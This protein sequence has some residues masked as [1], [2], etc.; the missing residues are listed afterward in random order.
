MNSNDVSLIPMHPFVRQFV[1]SIIKNIRGE[2]FDYRERPVIHADMVP[3]GSKGVRMASMM[4][5]PVLESAKV[6]KPPIKIAPRRRDMSALVAPIGRTRNRGGQRMMASRQVATLTR[7]EP[8]I[9]SAEGTMATPVP[10]G[11][12]IISE[13]YGKI[14]PLLDDP[15][16]STIECEGVNKPIM[17]L[18]A[19]QRQKTRVALTKEEIHEILEK[20]ADETH[21]PLLEGVFRAVVSG[22]S[23]NAVISEMIGSRF[24]I[25]KSNAYSML[26]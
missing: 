25:K 23:I 17:I 12:G 13:G 5:S 20:V 22:F 6:V 1:F 24:V 10:S 3:K 2:E 8:P 16:I 26:E 4:A 7:I 11:K 15:S 21:I 19:A 18:R 9:A 14:A